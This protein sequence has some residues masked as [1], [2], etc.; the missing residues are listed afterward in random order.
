MK[1]FEARPDLAALWK[2]IALPAETD[3]V[4]TPA[5]S[6]GTVHGSVLSI[7]TNQPLPITELW[8]KACEQPKVRR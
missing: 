4:K 6:I 3:A 8:A 7:V 5:V 1:E 2:H